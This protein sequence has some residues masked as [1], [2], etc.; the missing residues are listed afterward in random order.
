[1]IEVTKEDAL[2]AITWFEYRLDANPDTLLRKDY[3]LAQKLYAAGGLNAPILIKG[4]AM[5]DGNNY[6]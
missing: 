4:K 1:M 5:S 3:L 2:L 6:N